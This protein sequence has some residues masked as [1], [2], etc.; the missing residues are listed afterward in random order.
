MKGSRN[1][2]Q[3][4]DS[5]GPLAGPRISALPPLLPPQGWRAEFP[6]E[7]LPTVGGERGGQAGIVDMRNVQI[8][9]PQPVL[10]TFHA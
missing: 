5:V 6:L 3:P 10:V 7:G 2:G 8:E 1:K 4:R 9:V